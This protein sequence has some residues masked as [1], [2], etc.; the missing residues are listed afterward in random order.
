M[1]LHSPADCSVI[2]F[3]LKHHSL[4]FPESVESLKVPHLHA[5]RFGFIPGAVSFHEMSFV[6]DGTQISGH[7][8]PGNRLYRVRLP[9]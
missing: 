2:G 3:V 1:L 4:E 6:G 5:L 9:V 7:K 8:T